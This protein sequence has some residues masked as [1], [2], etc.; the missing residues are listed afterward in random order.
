MVSKKAFR[1]VYG[2]SGARKMRRIRRRKAKLVAK[3]PN[4]I[5]AFPKNNR[6]RMRY[7]ETKDLTSTSGSFAQYTFSC[8][9]LHDPNTTGTGHQPLGYDQWT[10]FYKSYLVVGA[11]ISIYPS[12]ITSGT[13]PI[14]AGIYLDD[15]V[16][17]S[18]DYTKLIEQGNTKYTVINPSLV[19]KIR[20]LTHH[21]S[22]KKYWKIKDVID[23]RDEYGANFGAN[24]TKEAQWVVWIQSS[25]LTATSS[26]RVMV[27]IDYIVDMSVQIELPQS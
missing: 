17:A 19:T 20:K 26:V 7:V 27:V 8:N 10:A 2:P 6:I 4:S 1:T 21:Y 3:M 14:Y 12:Y 18:G 25:D 23:N 22:P 11:K 16:T 15:T 24:P 5:I 9:D 13:Q